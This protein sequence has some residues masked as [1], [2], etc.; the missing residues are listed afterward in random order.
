MAALLAGAALYGTTGAVAE[1]APFVYAEAFPF[2]TM[3]PA[4]A[5]LNPDMLVTQNTYDALTRYDEADPAT[6]LP[7][8]ATSWTQ[9]GNDWTFKLRE[10]VKF[11]DGKPF[12]AD[13]VKASIDR[14]MKMSQG[15][16]FL[17]YNIASVDVVDPTTVVI[18][19]K[20]GNPWLPAN[21]TKVGIA[22]AQDIKDH[23]TGDDLAAG[24]FKDNEN[25]TGAYKVTGNNPGTDLTLSRNTDWWGKFSDHPVETF[26]DRFVTD[27]TQRFI[28]L[29]GGD[30]QLAAFISTD[31]ALSL[32]KDKFH[33]AVG[34]NLWAYPN[35]NLNPNI[36]PTSNPDFRAAMV[37][38]FDYKAMVDYY[39]GY[40]TTSNGPIPGWVPGSPNDKLETIKQDLDKAKQLLDKSG[41]KDG[42]FTCAIP[43]GSPDYDF[44]GQVLQA[45]AG[46]LGVTVELNQVPV[47]QI[48]DMM[49]NGQVACAVY[50]EASNS[51]DPVPFFTA[52]YYKGTYLNLW[53]YDD[54]D[55]VKLIETYSGATDPA[56][57]DDTLLKISQKLV[58]AHIDLWTV[59]PQ[60][61]MPMPNSVQGYKVDPFN[62]INVDIADL[63]YTP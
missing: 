59:S 21:L 37:A 14:M 19:A 13:D 16:S 27:G 28:G 4:A 29:K 60:T 40:A 8:L 41:V 53:N 39:K 43:A 20:T 23:A 57:R 55:M 26:I 33:L 42:K 35:L 47:A 48:P 56:V 54:A 61:V 24:W 49:K 17:L 9:N 62:L 11:H 22:S 50:G 15:L 18:H 46:S 10:G 1:T 5:G 44:V 51:P 3:D 63:S 52:R 6:I 45:A 25:G 58:D 7:A 36:E 2:S 34:N 31:N 30:Y 32:D 38:A 12:T